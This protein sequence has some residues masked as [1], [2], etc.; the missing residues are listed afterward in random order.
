MTE[1]KV[2]IINKKFHLKRRK[3]KKR[4]K[5]LKNRGIKHVQQLL[6]VE[7]YTSSFLQKQRNLK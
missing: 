7:K 2:L 4:L 5:K 1:L 3:S 6:I